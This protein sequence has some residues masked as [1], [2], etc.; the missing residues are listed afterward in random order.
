MKLA[1][2]QGNPKAQNMLGLM[3]LEGNGVNQSSQ[4]AK[5]YFEAAAK[6]GF[7]E[8]ENNLGWIYYIGEGV[9]ENL[10]EARKWFE[11][12]IHHGYIAAQDNLSIV[13]RKMPKDHSPVP[14]F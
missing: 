8:A 6:Q 7:A 12:A 9:N 5:I 1:A 4:E 11:L 14:K 2:K 13:K 3:Y 10:E